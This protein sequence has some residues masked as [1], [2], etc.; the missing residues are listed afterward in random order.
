MK[1]F[2]LKLINDWKNIYKN[3][4]TNCYIC[5]KYDVYKLV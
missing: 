5:V 3:Y 4:V 2:H 1:D